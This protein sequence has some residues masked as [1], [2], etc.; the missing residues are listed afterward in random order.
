MF[1]Y[2]KQYTNHIMSICYFVC[3]TFILYILS[4]LKSLLFYGLYYCLICTSLNA[5]FAQSLFVFCLLCMSLVFVDG[6]VKFSSEQLFIF[7][8]NIK[9]NVLKPNMRTIFIIVMFNCV[10]CYIC[11][12]HNFRKLNLLCVMVCWYFI[13]KKRCKTTHL[14]C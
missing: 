11:D 12:R 6:M 4:I 13:W 3:V 14:S 5:P 7:L 10:Y 1:N 2:F 9:L 8:S